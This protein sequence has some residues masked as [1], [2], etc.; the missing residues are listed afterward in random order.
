MSFHFRIRA[1]QKTHSITNAPDTYRPVVRQLIDEF[2]SGS[3]LY[4]DLALSHNQGAL[5]LHWADVSA[6]WIEEI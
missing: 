1:G 2:E 4:E 5:R 3:H 6:M